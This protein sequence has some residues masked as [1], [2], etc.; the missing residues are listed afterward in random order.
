M[1]LKNLVP[2]IT[3]NKI[4]KKLIG[5]DIFG[6]LYAYAYIITTS[7]YFIYNSIC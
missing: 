3:S 4:M 5:N 7:A 6:T 1:F 2:F